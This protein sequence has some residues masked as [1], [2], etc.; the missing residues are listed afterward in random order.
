[1]EV[2]KRY[3]EQLQ[4]TVETMRRH[5]IAAYDLGVKVGQRSKALAEKTYEAGESAAYDFSDQVIQALSEERLDPKDKDTRN[6]LV[7]L[8]L[9]EFLVIIF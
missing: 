3:L 5:L 2:G 8:Y 6:N 4:T 9:G 1:M 7:E